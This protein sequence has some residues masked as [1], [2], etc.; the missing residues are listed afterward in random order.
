MTIQVPESNNLPIT[1]HEEDIAWSQQVIPSTP[2]LPRVPNY[3]TF[4]QPVVASINL[5]SNLRGLNGP[6]GVS[7]EPTTD[8]IYVVGIEGGQIYIFSQT[9]DYIN[10]FGDIHLIKPWGIQ[11][12]RDNIYVTDVRLCEIIRF[13]IP[14]LKMIQRVGKGGSGRKEFRFPRQLA[15]SPKQ[16]LYVAD[17][18][19]D[20]L[21]ILTTDLKFQAILEHQTMTKPSDVKFSNNEMFVLSTR[22]NPC[23]HVFTLS[24]EESRSLVTNGHGMQIIQAW[25]FCMDLHSNF[26]IS[27]RTGNTIR[28]FSPGGHLLH[29]IGQRGYGPGEVYDPLGI[30][31]HNN[32]RLICVSTNNQC[33]LQIFS[34]YAYNS[35]T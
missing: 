10:R 2:P 30:T 34:E 26:I 11:I 27:D 17:Q 3:A 29:T 22:D 13:R 14:E 12:Y 7:I 23:I 20:R 19:N 16:Q 25:F 24:G 28:V 31:L 1:I 15:I 6:R 21:Q 8:Y 32:N 33:C 35:T 9:G 5:G 4:I 18:L